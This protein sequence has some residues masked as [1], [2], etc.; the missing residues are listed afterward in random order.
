MIAAAMGAQVIAIDIDDAKLAL[1]KTM[2]ASITINGRSTQDVPQAIRDVSD[3]G[4]HVSIDALGHP[5]TSFNSISC[6]R[7]RG[8]HVQVG[9]MLGD[10]STPKIPMA[11]V[12]SH[13]L[14]ILGSHGMQAHRYSDMMRMIEAGILK[15][16]QLI[17]KRISLDEAPVALSNMDKFEG[18]GITMITL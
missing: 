18:L 9:L 5:V 17:A 13:E 16:Q 8:R 2:G 15:P 4:A 1:A 3:G 12:I 14:E 11:R 6:L 7:R 10:H